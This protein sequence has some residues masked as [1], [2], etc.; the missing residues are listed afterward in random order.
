MSA[1]TPFHA[2]LRRNTH[3]HRLYIHTLLQQELQQLTGTM[4]PKVL[5]ALKGLVAVLLTGIVEEGEGGNNPADNNPKNIG[6][7]MIAEQSDG[8]TWGSWR[9]TTSSS[10]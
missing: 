3:T 1:S 6:L 5:E 8:S 10:C 2:C 7:T 4:L 9:C